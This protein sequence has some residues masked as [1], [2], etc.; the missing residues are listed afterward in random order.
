MRKSKVVF[1]R[2]TRASGP[3]LV[4]ALKASLDALKVEYIDYGILTTPMLHHMVRC[5][6]TKNSPHPFGEASEEGYY[7]K[8]ANAFKKAM[9]GRKINGHLTVD[10]AN[11]VGGPKL[12]DLLKYLPDA[13]SG[14][15]D[16]KVVNDDVIKPE[17][18]NHDVS[19]YLACKSY[20]LT[21]FLSSVV[22]TT[23][24][25]NSVLLHPQMPHRSND[26][27][28]LTEMLIALSITSLT[29]TKNFIYLT[30]T[31][32]QRWLQTSLL[33]RREWLALVTSLRLE[34]FKPLMPM[35]R[36]PNISRR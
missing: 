31:V 1:A 3:H 5:Q 22:P 7:Q 15:I 27:A 6:N 19:V 24:K 35:A 34:L 10:C 2:D 13:K 32:S 21:Y 18:L 8:M 25:Q 9:Y 11:G 12:H 26:A 36:R 14:G 16:V 20:I 29:T 23:S 33:I 17:A 4:K 28:L 30:V